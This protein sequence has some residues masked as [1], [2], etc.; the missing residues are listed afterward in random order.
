[1]KAYVDKL[2]NKEYTII[3]ADDCELDL[4]FTEQILH[5]YNDKFR[6]IK[7]IDGLQACQMAIEEYPDI[8]LIDLE[9]PEMDGLTVIKFLKNNFRTK[10]IPIIVFTA[11]EVDH[12]V[13]EQDII[14]FIE[15]P[16]KEESL[17]IR[18]R[19]V[20][21]L[22]ES[23]RAIE[24][25][26]I[27]IEKR[28]HK[29]KKQHEDVLLQKN[30][31][32]QKN[33]EI[34]AD[35][36]YSQR[37]QQAMLPS[38]DQVKKILPQ[39]FI[40]NFPKNVVSGDFYWLNKNKD[41]ITI[42][43]GDCTG[44]GVSGA[45]MHMMGVIFL[46]E[47]IKKQQ[48]SNPGSILEQLRNKVMSSLH[49]TGKYGEAQDGMDISLCILDNKSKV[50]YFAGANNPV[51][52]VNNKNFE[53]IRADRMPVGIN[54]N[55]DK[56]FTTKKIQLEKGDSIYMFTDGYADQFGGPK[57]KKFRY[58]YFKE[59]IVSINGSPMSTQKKIMEQTFLKWKGQH[60]QVDD[61][62]IMGIKI[63]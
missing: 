31:I 35:L 49:Q 33:E 18:I 34:M 3:I 25:Q 8:I 12:E 38:K 60:E 19:S 23:Y 7:A 9:M 51:Y 24:K 16:F 29:I 50:L 11:K 1:M 15:K 26:K 43:V 4:L 14:D 36:R 52:I 46:N 21:N 30:I 10:N 17:L 56:P 32:T 55:Y 62:L 53:E 5:S 42:A 40:V 27:E 58:K 6:I 45:L 41:L 20:L 22:V 39:H 48:G 28:N 2:R 37:I 13:F 57:G 47:I 44:H 54:I 61:V 63:S 59:L